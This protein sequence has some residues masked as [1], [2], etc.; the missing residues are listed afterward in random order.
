[1]T[2]EPETLMEAIEM[3]KQGARVEIEAAPCVAIIP[4]EHDGETRDGLCLSVRYRLSSDGHVSI[5]MKSYSRG[6]NPASEDAA[7]MAVIIANARLKRDY[8]LLR[9]GG[10]P[11]QRVFFTLSD[12]LPEAENDVLKGRSCVDVRDVVRMVRLGEHVRGRV[13]MEYKPAGPRA[14]K[15]R[16][17]LISSFVFHCGNKIYSMS[18]KLGSIDENSSRQEMRNFVAEADSKLRKIIKTLS[19]AGVS[20]NRCCLSVEELALYRDYSPV[21]ESWSES[22]SVTGALN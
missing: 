15:C 6:H 18:R 7:A 22:L 3:K 19:D 16:R 8:D 11:C 21:P 2:T 1:M 20:I 4:C 9:R 14:V 5:M 10:I 13:T 17:A 12:V